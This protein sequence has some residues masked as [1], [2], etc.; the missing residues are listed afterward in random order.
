[1]HSSFYLFFWGLLLQYN[2]VFRGFDILPDFI[3]FIFIYKGLTTLTVDS[4]YFT[5]ARRIILPLTGLSLVNFY[6]FQYQPDFLLTITTALDIFKIIVF[7][8]T[9][10]LVYN[11][12]RGAIEVAEDLGDDYLE[13]TI[14]QRLYVYLGIAGIF[15]TIS[16]VSLFPFTNVS[17]TMQTLFVFT[18][19]VYLFA[20][21]IIASGMYKMYKELRPRPANQVVKKTAVKR[22]R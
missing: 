1:M 4:K 7:S 14:R 19:L 20:L 9:M 15:L 16:V 22:K 5:V 3:G 10:Y 17:A 8:L 13:T 12:F 18:Y 11:L 2:I 6:N 21:L